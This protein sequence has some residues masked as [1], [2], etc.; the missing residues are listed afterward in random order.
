MADQ[1]AVGAHPGDVALAD[2]EQL[3]ARPQHAPL[4]HLAKR[5][6]GFG[7]LGAGGLQRRGVQAAHPVDAVGGD[8][9]VGF[10]A[11][12]ADEVTAEHLG[13]R[14]GGAGAKERVEDHI[15]GVG[16]RHDDPVQQAFRLLGRMRL[17]AVFILEPLMAGA[18]RQQP[19]RAH[20]D[21]IVQRL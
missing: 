7:A 14:S 2:R 16:R 13:N 21:T 6:T 3:L 1:G 9:S 17:V 10:F 4:H 20:L 8:P 19:I 18:D 11:F 5:D 15:A 12:N